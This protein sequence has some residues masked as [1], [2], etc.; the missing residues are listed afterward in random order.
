ME[1]WGREN[2]PVREQVCSGS[3]GEARS[4]G[5]WTPGEQLGSYHVIS[6]RDDGYEPARTQGG[7]EPRSELGKSGKLN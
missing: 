2:A 7:E 6:M 5:L 4:G 1:D 3:R